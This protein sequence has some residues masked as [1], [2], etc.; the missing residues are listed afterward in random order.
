MDSDIAAQLQELHAR[1]CKAIADPKR[2]MI[3]N[4]LR[5]RELSVGDLCEALGIS[6]SNASQHLAVLRER[7]LVSSHRVGT[8][9]FY[10]LRSQKIVQAVDLLR[11]FLAEDLA[12]QGRLSGAITG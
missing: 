12:E 4:E 8:N 10:A 1:V 7:G 11:E 2:L 6:Q 3:I 9:V 5:D